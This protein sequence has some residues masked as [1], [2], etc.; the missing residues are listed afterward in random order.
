MHFAH[1]PNSH[2]VHTLT[3]TLA[4]TEFP[5]HAYRQ[6]QVLDGGGA[7]EEEAVMAG[8]GVTVIRWGGVVGWRGG[9]G[10]SALVRSASSVPPQTSHHMSI[11]SW[12]QTE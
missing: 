6:E 10:R 2:I 11:K 4:L 12:S 8:E 7:G 9:E 5:H 1:S 3:L